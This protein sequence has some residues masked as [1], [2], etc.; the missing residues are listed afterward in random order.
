MDFILN[1]IESGGKLEIR[2]PTIVNPPVKISD[3]HSWFGN[4]DTA[5]EATIKDAVSSQLSSISISDTVNYLNN[6][7]SGTWVGVLAR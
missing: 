2:E 7:F 3:Y 1:Y 5:R 4:L 6:M